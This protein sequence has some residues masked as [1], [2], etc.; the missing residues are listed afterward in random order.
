[1]KY[2]VLIVF[3]LLTLTSYSQETTLSSNYKKE[4]IEKLSKLINDFY[5]YPAI[6][7]KTSKHLNSEFQSGNFDRYKDHQAFANGLTEAVQHINK[8]KHMRII[9]NKPY[10][11]PEHSLERKAAQRMD[12]INN[13][14][15]FNHGVREVKLLDGNVAYLDLRGFAT[16]DRAKEITDTYMKLISQADAVIID[17]SNNGGGDPAMVQYVCSY[18]FNQKLHLNSLYYRE[19]DRTE[20]YWTLEEVGGKKMDKVPLFI[21]ISE[22]TFSGAEEFS[23]NMQTQQRATLIGQTSGGGANPGG[24]RAINKDLAVFIP[25]GRAINPI[26]KTSWEGTGV[27]PEIKT[28][29]K[30]TFSQAYALAKAKAE[31]MRKN[32]TIQYI[33]LHKE[34][35]KHLDEYKNDESELNIHKH[36]SNFVDAGLFGEWDINSLGFDYLMNKNKSKIALCILKSN[37]VLFPNSPNV[38]DSYGEALKI[39]G[40]LNA[41][42]ASY[43][44]AVDIAIKSKD[45]NLAY[46]KEALQNINDEIKQRN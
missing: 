19:G 38:F 46:Y 5:I 22:K 43:Q 39:T 11:A 14:R 20:E 30:E 21:M 6:G 7:Q 34:L 10:K 3:T 40:D 27:I 37:T 25:T 44:K 12:Q 32:K 33:R 24:T 17:L 23:Y 4:V 15:S 35:N 42:V 29:K 28:T 8:D 31:T 16:L 2:F 41:S 13:Y 9:A 26:T 45:K 1:M 36:I 18:F